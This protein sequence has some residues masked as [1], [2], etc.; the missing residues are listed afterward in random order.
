MK[1]EN[2]IILHPVI[3]SKQVLAKDFFLYFGF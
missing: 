3:V 2:N 1:V